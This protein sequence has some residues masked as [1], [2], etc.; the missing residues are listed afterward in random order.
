MSGY[1]IGYLSRELLLI[2]QVF[3][4]NA[5]ARIFRKQIITSLHANKS[6]HQ[7]QINKTT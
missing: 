6:A 3:Q 7:L 2:Q 4:N 1:S 5:E